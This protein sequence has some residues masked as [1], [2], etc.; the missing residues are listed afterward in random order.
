MTERSVAVFNGQSREARPTASGRTPREGS[1]GES[2]HRRGPRSQTRRR[3]GLVHLANAIEC[4]LLLAQ[5]ERRLAPKTVVLYAKALTKVLAFAQ[6]K[7]RD[8]VD[9]LTPN[10]LRAAA[11]FEMD[12]T[13]DHVTRST[14]WRGGE[15]MGSCMVS[16]T[17]TMVRRLGEEYPDLNLPDLSMVKAPRVP[18][19]I[20]PRLE[21]GEFAQLEATLR[22]RLL[23]DR[24]PRFLIAR[25]QAILTLLGN[26]GLRAEECCNLN[27]ED[28]D[29][30]EGAVSIHHGKG[31]K[32]RILTILDPDPAERDGGEVLR[33]LIDYLRYRERIFGPAR[34]LAL[35]LTPHGNRLNPHGLRQMLSAL[36]DEAGLDGNRPPHA[37]RRAYFTEQYRDQPLALPVLVERMGWESDTMAKVYTRGVDVELARRIPLP[38][39]SKKW[40]ARSPKVPPGGRPLRPIMEEDVGF[41]G[42]Q[43]NDPAHA[44]FEED[45]NR[46][47]SRNSQRSPRS[48]L[49]RSP[50]RLQEGRS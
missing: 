48:P 9:D 46:A 27:I 38:L 2:N 29:L 50:G 12:T 20:Q 24:V 3:D 18:K 17:R 47:A 42:R 25:D 14:N 49:Y 1:A 13:A 41:R 30:D 4:F 23:R 21:E 31:D 33:A 35:W 43:S 45:V 44:H 22:I 5:T 34:S 37:F 15:G 10:L 26:T 39:Q 40:R 16:A 19:R 11:A 6:S 7:G 8:R 32:W 36:C 28:V